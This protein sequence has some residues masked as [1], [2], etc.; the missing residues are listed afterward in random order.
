MVGLN[1]TAFNTMTECSKFL[2]SCFPCDIDQATRHKDRFK[3]LS[4]QCMHAY[5]M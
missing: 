5:K 3:I 1:R 4:R 2:N